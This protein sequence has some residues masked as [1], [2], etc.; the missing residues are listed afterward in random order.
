MH[1]NIRRMAKNKGQVLGFL[2]TLKEEFDII[3]LTE[4]NN[5]AEHH[6]NRNF[7]P[8]YDSFIDTPKHNRYGRNDV[9]IK[10]GYG[11]AIPREE[12]KMTKS[13]TSENCAYGNTW[14]EIKTKNNEF[15]IGALY[16]HPNG[17]VEHFVHDMDKALSQVP[18]RLSCFLAGDMNIDLLKF[19]N[20]LTFEYF[21][22]NF[23]PFI[24]APTHTKIT[25]W[26][27]TLIDH[28][29]VK[30]NDRNRHAS[31]L[32]GNILTDIADHL[33]NGLILNDVSQSNQKNRPFV[34]MFSEKKHSK[35]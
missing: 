20:N 11:S 27:S 4:I 19:E 14:I 34:R 12:L 22:R 3:L 2:S 5:D 9:L 30:L 16:R 35:I 23:M 26:T 8:R 7:L 1:I 10:Q 32:A 15:I 18:K 24:S 25:D 21:T 29:F 28:I 6:I 17:N 31:V 13:C 33:P